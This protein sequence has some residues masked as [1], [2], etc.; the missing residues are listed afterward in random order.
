MTPKI[1]GTRKVG[2][3]LTAFRGEW[4]PGLVTYSYQ[5]YRRSTPISGANGSTYVARSADRKK[6]VYVTVTG[7]RD[8]Y[9]SVTKKS[10]GV[11]VA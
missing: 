7:S 9:R 8:G 2:K 6:S 5:W 11:K 4:G 10:A 3:K 1:S